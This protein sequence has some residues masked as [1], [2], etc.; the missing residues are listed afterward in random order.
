MIPGPDA[1]S[2]AGPDVA[3]LVTV[4][5]AGILEFDRFD[6][7]DDFFALGGDSVSAAV[8][9]RQ[10]ATASQ[11][12]IPPRTLFEHPS[13]SE[14]TAFV[15][16]SRQS[17]EVVAVRPDPASYPITPG[18]ERLWLLSRLHPDR[19][20]YSV[21]T[22]VDLAGALDR[23]ALS[24]A[25]SALAARHE[26]LRTVIQDSPAG[27]TGRV[28]DPAP[29]RVEAQPCADEDAARARVAS[30]LRQPF[31]LSA[32]PPIRVQL[33]RIG[34]AAHWLVL[35]I[36]HIA[37]DSDSE[38]ILLDELAV[39]YN[40]ALTGAPVPLPPLAMTYGDIASWRARKAAAGPGRG[41]SRQLG[42]LRGLADRPLAL[43][44]R[45]PDLAAG[46]GSR[47]TMWLGGPLTTRVR[48]CAS[49]CH[50]TVF[51]TLLAAFS[52]IAAR[53]SGSDDVCVGYPVSVRDPAPAREIAGFFID[54][55]AVRVDLSDEPSFASVIGQV[56]SDVGAAV[57]DAVPFD[58]LAEAVAAER[59]HRSPLFRVWFNHLGRPARP[60]AMDG[61]ATA[62]LDIPVPPALFDLNIYVTDHGTDIR[63]DVVYDID[64]CSDAAADEL[65]GQY[66]SVLEQAVAGPDLPLR[67]HRCRTSRSAGLPD[68]GDPLLTPAPP[69]LA[70]RLSVV[71]RRRGSSIAIK[72]ADGELSFS[73]LRAAVRSLANAAR[74]AG[75]GPG[76]TVGVHTARGPN[77]VIAM[78]AVWAAGA[79]SLLLDP[80]YPAA[81]LARYL[82]TGQA[83][84]L[85]ADPGPVPD[86]PVDGLIRLD[87]G[88]P[89]VVRAA[90]ARDP[91]AR[92]RAGYLA[93]TSGSTGEPVGVAGGIEPV[94]HFLHWY[95]TEYR[96]GAQDRFALLAGLAHDPVLRDA[97]L[98]LWN[99]G[100]LC[101]PAPATFGDPVAL[102]SWLRD[103]QVTVVNLTPPLA[104]VLAGTGSSLP[105]LRLICLGADAPTASDVIR[106]A[107]LAPRAVLVNGYGTT[108]T[109]QLVSHRRIDG[110]GRPALG[111]RAPGS[112]L[113]VVDPRGE[114]CGIGQAG[115]ILIRGRYLA[116]RLI[117][118]GQREP[119]GDRG[120]AALTADPVPGVQRFRTGDLG[121]YQADGS[122][123]YLGR[124]DDIVSIRGFRVHPAETDRALAADP[125]LHASVTVPWPGPDGLE[126]VSY[127]V[128][129]GF[130]PTEIRSR[131]AAIVPA[132]FV[133]TRIIPLDRLPLTGNGKIDKAAL[134]DPHPAAAA[135]REAI[136]PGSSLEARLARTWSFVLGLDDVDVTATF[137]ELGGTSLKLLRLHSAIRREIADG[138]PLL[139][140]YQNPT[141]RSLARSI[142]QPTVSAASANHVRGSR[143]AERSR[144]LAARDGA[145]R[146]GD[147]GRHE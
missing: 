70:R 34:P 103:E 58:V 139:A 113:L 39:A 99:G 65:L 17:A 75:V 105:A 117:S 92:G 102:A 142:S 3:R 56:H 2:T 53:W 13:F 63:V 29:V 6:P 49:A 62:I 97:L 78:L 31:D 101:V 42:R 128:S 47:R 120:P 9:A 141:V 88:Q 86:L 89:V 115:A 94:A 146:T 55:C 8:V 124:A 108:E 140:L 130:A 134:P 137:F 100:T 147:G 136:A 71:S 87:R 16:A 144:R 23:G 43:E 44:G 143:A 35:A 18:Q 107:A 50:S 125:S 83:R 81:R 121:R 38:Q 12:R 84:C 138:L 129:T 5:W 112:Q 64:A 80:G 21:A 98:P 33:L 96:L 104:R 76:D 36:H 25:L 79:R 11:V 7:D 1:A 116:E 41:Y 37:T 145:G 20:S 109:P 127:V 72:S 95:S 52:D 106:L 51:V 122:V 14:F 133:P 110:P 131:L 90:T 26:P 85:I 28:L 40:A 54:T 135:S 67:R 119:A 24:S 123:A 45:R 69:G 111:A 114:R 57:A 32:E 48:E 46:V 4:A 19:A 126:L 60:P 118:A 22:I 30:F 91:A 74:S 73:E 82:E 93:F 10:V 77:V 59:G 132:P 68:P 61:L 66:L 27:P 15:A